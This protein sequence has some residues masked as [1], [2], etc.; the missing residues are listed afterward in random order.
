MIPY[1]ACVARPAEG[2]AGRCGGETNGDSQ[3]MTQCP[4][5]D[6]LLPDDARYCPACGAAVNAP[7]AGSVEGG[8]PED[9][10]PQTAAVDAD[11]TQII[12]AGATQVIDA[13]PTE[14]IDDDATQAIDATSQIAA[15]HIMM[16]P[17]GAWTCPNCGAEA[18][19]DDA[20]CVR[21][22]AA[23]PEEPTAVLPAPNLPCSACGAP[24]DEAMQFC[25]R[26]GARR[27]EP[28]TAASREETIV[29]TGAAAAVTQVAAPAFMPAE[30]AP[31]PP[32]PPPPPPSPATA[33]GDR[34]PSG[35]HRGRTAVIAALGVFLVAVAGFC[36]WWFV[37]RDTGPAARQAFV[38]QA[39]PL[40]T[41]VVAAQNDVNDALARINVAAG[42]SSVTPQSATSDFKKWQPDV[43]AAAAKLADAVKT[44]QATTDTL[45]VKQAAQPL[46]AH[47]KTA[48]VAHAAY[49]AALAGIAG[50]PASFTT[51]QATTIGTLA[52]AVR[53]AY[54]ALAASAAGL[55][56]VLLPANVHGSLSVAATQ[57]AAE[58][59][60][61]ASAKETMKTYL[62]QVAALFDQ[63][64]A[65]RET[66]EGVLDQ[67]VN[68][69]IPA[70]NAAGQMQ[71][72]G[73]DLRAG[74]TQVDALAPPSDQA[75][76]QIQ[77]DYRAA[78]EH[79][80]AAAR[81]YAKWMSTVFG[82]YQAQ[83]TYPQPGEPLEA[84]VFLDPS[85]QAAQEEQG[86]ADQMR[87][88]LAEAYDAQAAQL[89]LPA[90]VDAPAM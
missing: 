8:A 62:Q 75:A 68:T 42:A 18:P 81:L 48:L 39:T 46:L 15:T 86:L 89:G 25:P 11:A 9:V 36:V 31:S 80:T 30:P 41:P 28:E 84:D 37:L 51:T 10:G 71:G 63:T 67:F 22:G 3:T 85:Y 32:P 90:D 87:V 70:D 57:I 29:A 21:C 58:A 12:D 61:A 40:L 43:T 34:A 47:L 38:Q 27:G 2:A 54:A 49:A 1:N 13:E 20:F 82:Y 6:R 4:S 79:W 23:R 35:G 59:E 45:A 55:P 7:P 66:A 53:T 17:A 88:K 78:V 64:R 16:P 74:L 69:Q 24:L 19:V 83:G 14:P 72:A 60:A 73:A 44:A 52:S 50:E 26:C 77:N 5:C 76:Q 33:A 56:G 65:A